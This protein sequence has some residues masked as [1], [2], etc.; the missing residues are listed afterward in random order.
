M[1]RKDIG[2][3]AIRVHFGIIRR[4]RPGALKAAA[5]VCL[6]LLALLAVAQVTHVHA[7]GSDAD[8]CQICIAM[9]SIAPFMA[10]VA[11][12]LLVRIGTAELTPLEV[13]TICRY[14]HSTLFNRPP[15]VGC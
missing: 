1:P 9:H 15:P 2:L 12:A 11:G 3:I 5:V 10:F 13:G 14:W 8:H 4:S 6:V 7:V